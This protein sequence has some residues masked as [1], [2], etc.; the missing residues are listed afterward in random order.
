MH[1]LSSFS[2]PPSIRGRLS[3]SA[4][5]VALAV[6]VPALGLAFAYHGASLRQQRLRDARELAAGL[7]AQ[8]A[9]ALSLDDPSRAEA[10]LEALREHPAVVFAALYN[11]SGDL[12]A[13][14]VRAL[15]GDPMP[16]QSA[17]QGA[18]IADLRL[19]QAQLQVPVAHNGMRLGV[20]L[21][22]TDFTG[23]SRDLMGDAWAFAAL[24][25]FAGLAALALGR[26]LLSPISTPIEKLSARL[27]QLPA[28]GGDGLPAR[29]SGGDELDTLTA[30]LDAILGRLESF[31]AELR[32][33][34]ERLGQLVVERTRQV[35]QANAE[36]ENMVRQLRSA[37]EVAEGASLAKSR[38][39]ANMSHEIRTP[40]NGVLGMTELLLRSSL[41]DPQRR[42]AETVRRSGESL[43]SIINDVLDFSRIEAGRLDLQCTDFDLYETIEDVVEALASRA[44]AKGLEIICLSDS[45]LPRMRGDPHRVRQVM[46]NLVGNAIKFT[47]RGEVVVRARILLEDRRSVLVGVEVRDTGVG[48]APEAAA[49]I[50]E[51]FAQADSS[52]TRRYEGTGLGLAISKQLATLMGGDIDLESRPGSGSS[53]RFTARF[54]RAA[55]GVEPEPLPPIPTLRVLVVDD[56]QANGLAMKQQC[57]RLGLAADVAGGADQA[58]ARLR[59]AARC[60][61]PYDVGLLDL[62]M[63][64]V[65][66]LTLAGIIHGDAAIGS[67]RLVLLVTLDEIDFWA[68]RVAGDVDHLTKPVQLRTLARCLAGLGEAPD[69]RRE[70]ASAHGDGLAA[71][72]FLGTRV[73][74]AEDSP[75]NQEVAR[76]L[77]AELGC[78]VQVCENGQQALEAL[79]RGRFDAVLM[80]CMMPVLDGFEATAALRRRERANPDRQRTYVV[81]LTASAMRG[82]RERCLDAGMDD[83]LAKPYRSED[84]RATL[85]RAFRTGLAPDLPSSELPPLAGPAAA[86]GTACLDAQVLA[87]LE[88]LRLPGKPALLERVVGLYLEHS[89]PLLEEGRIAL[90]APD[91]AMLRRALHTL[92]SSSAN[93]GATHL[94]ALCHDYEA[95]LREGW[96]DDGP[97]QFARIEAELERV[98]SALRVLVPSAIA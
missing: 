30:G 1:L 42:V 82:D 50:F 10:A 59:E 28:S 52:T 5:R 24:A 9:S 17:P 77:L 68:T 94:S 36:L 12:V 40:M 85:L 62:R 51:V 73:L 20:L 2:R 63:P 58:L 25:A 57:A 4:L 34:R 64:G 55:A 38:F 90:A 71:Q 32:Q 41:T 33:E 75:V 26:R 65:D 37:K 86:V 39:L 56:N 18:P 43:L 6:L 84:L 8:L 97:R 35:S 91:R 22:R 14:F 47:E 44:H 46:T 67:I 66:G 89:S 69:E 48:I 16:P 45:A 7:A 76:E 27:C 49:R 93:V 78:E 23:A 13:R 60:A 70:G 95:Q 61:R 87:S 80:D 92:K 31:D 88:S 3:G 96:P 72:P 15:A 53:F 54:E 11:R 21:L 29:G 19:G 98:R 74:L 79:A 83:Y 81:A